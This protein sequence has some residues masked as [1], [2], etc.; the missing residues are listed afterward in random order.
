MVGITRMLMDFKFMKHISK[1]C[2]LLLPRPFKFS[3]NLGIF[4]VFVSVFSR[5]FLQELLVC[6]LLVSPPARASLSSHRDTGHDTVLVL[7]YR[8]FQSDW[9]LLVLRK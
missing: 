1:L 8:G 9:K 6:L 4:L 7:G 3:E 5:H 2:R